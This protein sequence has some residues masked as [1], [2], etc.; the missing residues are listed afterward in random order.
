MVAIKRI[1]WLV[2]AILLISLLNIK[3]AKPSIIYVDDDG[4]ADYSK[5]QEAIDNAMPG[6]TI[7]VY[8]GI[9]QENII[10]DKEVYLKGEKAII[11]CYN[12][13]GIIV[14]ANGVIISNFDIKNSSEGYYAIKLDSVSNCIIRNCNFSFNYG[15]IYAYNGNNNTIYM[16]TFYSN[17]YGF[18]AVGLSNSIIKENVFL[19]N[20][21]GIDFGSNTRYN[22]FYY[23]NFINNGI[24]AYDDSTFNEWCHLNVG[25]YWSKYVGMD[26]DGDGI[27]DVPYQI[28]PIEKGNFDY[29]PLMETYIGQ[30]IY[31]PDINNIRA[32]PQ[33]QIPNLFV[34]ISCEIVDNVG[35]ANV[36]I[37]ISFPNGTCINQSM[38]AIGSLYYFNN[39]FYQKGVYNYYIWAID[40]NNNSEKSSIQKFVI[41]Y[42]PTAN[43]SY[44][45]SMPTILDN[46]I[47]NST[48]YDVDGYIVNYTWYFDEEI[49]YGKTVYYKFNEKSPPPHHVKLIVY[50]NDGAWDIIEKEIIVKNIPPT[51]DFI[52][53]PENPEAGQEIIF[54]DQSID[55]DGNIYIW[56]WDFGDGSYSYERNPTHAYSL[57]GIYNVTLTVTDNDYSSNS[58]TKTINVIDLIPPK[59]KNISAHPNPQEIDEVVNISCIIIDNVRVSVATINITTPSGNFINE[60][61]QNIDNIY[62]YEILCNEEGEYKYYIFAK[63]RKGNINRTSIKNFTIIVPPLPPSICNISIFPNTQQYGYF[64]N[65]S[66]YVYDNVGVEE[67]RIIL[68]GQNMS[69]D[70]IVD[71]K[72]N[73]IYYINSSF[74][75]GV[76]KFFIYASD[77]NGYINISSNYSFIVVDSL[78][79]IIKNIS[80]EKYVEP[81]SFINISCKISDNQGVK[82]TILYAITPD[83]TLNISMQNF[84]SD[85]YV[86]LKCNSSGEY[87]FYIWTIDFSNNT[88][89]TRLYN[90]TVTNLPIANFSYSPAYPSNLDVIQFIDE[91]YDLDG[92][93]INYTWN[94]GD[95]SIA[96]GKNVSHRYSLAG[97]YNVT[98]T[99]K[100]NN[101]AISNITKEI[102][103]RAVLIANFTYIPSHPLSGEIISFIDLSY[104]ASAWKWDFGDGS[105]SYQK[106]TSHIYPIGNYY[107]VTLTIYNENL[108]LS[109]YKIVK[110]DTKVMLFKNEKNVVNY[111]AWISNS[112]TARQLAQ[113]IGDNIMPKGSVISKW[114]VSQGKFDDYIVGISPPSYDFVIKPGDC[115][116]LRVANSG[117]FVMEVIE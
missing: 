5:I 76:H 103:V 21:Y 37:N 38:N 101:N 20:S 64:V 97:T 33:I 107:N 42:K 117:N 85:F 112:T 57:D 49:K 75:M 8:E 79:P 70:S 100:D 72:G 16:N 10:I 26:K 27:G 55:A 92:Y 3:F 73:G 105:V 30:D 4:S 98:L 77:I 34:N 59:I 88:N 15:G 29:Y 46:V 17:S 43:F 111:V 71:S 104:G 66:C 14:K 86:L 96:Y 114:N 23:N 62:Y 44:S 11:E 110:V 1:T 36:F 9:Y 95:G 18:S 102:S 22:I 54:L 51:P 115:V 13:H 74:D 45:P 2:T 47:F 65:I 7:Y 90:F 35:V 80:F 94:F 39:T 28:E 91:S 52:F 48:S 116:V 106:N 40:V 67:V 87:N 56:K 81:G 31:P 53:T 109:T 32:N 6:D 113:I 69:M 93:I 78:P 89:S 24:D 99:V 19:Y 25:N 82:N 60:S 68:D 84:G 61:M 63:D 83:K 58:I 12:G 41:G 108:S 50:D